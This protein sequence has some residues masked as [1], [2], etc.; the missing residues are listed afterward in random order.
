MT[1]IQTNGR[2]TA[3]DHYVKMA[4][5][6]SDVSSS[7]YASQNR[8]MC[9][10]N[11]KKSKS[12]AAKERRQ[13]LKALGICTNCGT[14]PATP[15]KNHCTACANKA[16]ASTAAWKHKLTSQEKLIRKTIENTRVKLANQ[17][18]KNDILSHY[19]AICSCEC[20]CRED[21]PGFLTIDHISGGG[22]KHRKEIGSSNFYRWIKKNNY[23]TEFRVLCFNC[24]CGRNT[25]PNKQCPRNS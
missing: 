15:K 4:P 18:L 25:T 3:E 10:P 7:V 2:N 16:C 13:K 20:G 24:N 22:H 23:P 8:S 1:R 19:N 21:I 17:A 9:L 14:L 11:D 5:G 6:S 12:V